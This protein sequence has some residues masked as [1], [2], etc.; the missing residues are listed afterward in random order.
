MLWLKQSYYDQGQ[1]AGKPLAWRI[2]KVQTDRAINSIK[3]ADGK[4]L[5]DLVD[6]NTAF[7]N[8]YEDLYK[9]EYPDNPEKLNDFLDQLNSPTLTEEAKTNLEKNLCIEELIEALKSMNSGKAPGPDGLPI[10][11]YKKFAGKLLP[12][13]LKMSN[14]SHEK[15]ILPPSLRSAVIST[16]TR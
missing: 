13:L 5:N 3:S 12:H 10:E 7:T 6:I 2:K 4:D 16:R 15:G 14:E 8:Y 1:K 9:S 11:L